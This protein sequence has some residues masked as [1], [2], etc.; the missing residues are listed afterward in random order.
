MYRSRSI[1]TCM[2]TYMHACMHACMHAYTHTY[3]RT[4][5][6]TYKPANEYLLTRWRSREPRPEDIQIRVRVNPRLRVN[7]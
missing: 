6:H 2:H 1:H 3:V 4:N 7:P 5:T